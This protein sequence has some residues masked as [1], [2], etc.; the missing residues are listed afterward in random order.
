MP[1]LRKPRSSKGLATFIARVAQSKQAEDI[2][3]LDLSKIDSAPSDFF[4]ICTCQ[5]DT[6]VRAVAE[7]ID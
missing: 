4:M 3:I 1:A 6:Q 7:A 2:L 5:S